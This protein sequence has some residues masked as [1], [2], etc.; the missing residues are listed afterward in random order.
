MW[1]LATTADDSGFTL[2]E[3]LIVIA[4]IAM[5]AATGS[6]WLPDAV[7]RLV[8]VHA[9][10][11]IEQELMRVAFEARRTG[12]DL[13]VR[14]NTA[15][16]RLIVADPDKTIRVDRRIKAAWVAAA[17]SG[18]VKDQGSIVYFGSGGASGGQLSLECGK[19]HSQITIDW[20]TGIV[21]EREGSRGDTH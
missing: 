7:D 18:S 14:I 9:E 12:R 19:A 16:D 11:Q 17:E 4:L 6:I 21:H 10:N 20:L 5:V 2:L 13:T 3:L 1:P 15:T 8:L